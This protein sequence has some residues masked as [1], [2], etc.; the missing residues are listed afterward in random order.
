VAP[1]AERFRGLQV[2]DSASEVYATIAPVQDRGDASRVASLDSPATNSS[3]AARPAGQ[4]ERPAMMASPDA[5]P[6]FR[7]AAITE[8]AV[9]RTRIIA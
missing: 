7:V 3:Q 9:R 6:S 1:E 8:E 2:H 5:M 4:V